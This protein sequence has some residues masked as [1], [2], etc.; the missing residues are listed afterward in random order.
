MR[1]QTAILGAILSGWLA[2]MSYAQPIAKLRFDVASVRQDVSGGKPKSN[3]AIGPGNVWGPSGGVLSTKN[4]SLLM[5]ISFAYKMT[6]Y[7]IS[8]LQAKLP[9]WASSERFDIEARTDKT[10]ATKDEMREMMRSLLADRFGLAVHYEIRNVPVYA[11]ALVKPGTEGPKL[12]QHPADSKCQDFSLLLKTA[13]G[14]PV[15]KL[16]DA[17]PDGFPTFCGGILGVPA[18]AQ[19]RYSFG[20][21]NVPVSMI[22]SSFSSWGNLGRPVV[23]E[24]GLRG[25]YDFVLDF[26]PDPRPSYATID[27]G[28][29]S[30]QEALKQQLGLKLEP[31]KGDVQFLVLDHLEHPTKN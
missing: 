11:M 1:G 16:P 29:P 10:N 12:R 2:L 21:G 26:T 13:D 24:T 19:D 8:A 9:D 14:K 18:S 30:F 4:F 23:D 15:V 28:G 31:A 7:Q 27:S 3:L 17:A 22:A 6:D 5:Y 25:M 20:A